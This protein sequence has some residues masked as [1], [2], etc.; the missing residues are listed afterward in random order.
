[1]MLAG[2]SATSVKATIDNGLKADRNLPG[3]NGWFLKT[4]D[5]APLAIGI[6]KRR[7]KTGIA[8]RPSPWRIL[9]GELKSQTHAIFFFT[10]QG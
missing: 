4:A 2:V 7:L 10:K 8:Q 9:L 1:M 3:G 6:S 5:K